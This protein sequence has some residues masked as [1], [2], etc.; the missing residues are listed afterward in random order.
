[1]KTFA[2]SPERYSRLLALPRPLLAYRHDENLCCIAGT[3]NHLPG[4][5]KEKLLS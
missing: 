4:R 5:G 3:I 2:V 1:M